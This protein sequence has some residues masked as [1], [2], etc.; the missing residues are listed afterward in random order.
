MSVEA[1]SMQNGKI[2]GHPCSS[3]H[4]SVIE[5]TLGWGH[6]LTL[7]VHRVKSAII[8]LEI[9]DQRAK[10]MSI[11][12]G[13]VSMKCL[14]SFPTTAEKYAIQSFRNHL[15]SVFFLLSITLG[16]SRILVREQPHCTL[17]LLRAILSC[18]SC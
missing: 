12:V 10:L 11:D 18:L 13:V 4:P 16:T 2:R 8:F 7:K 5:N 15:F 6:I 9:D 17:L 3:G 1:M 14:N